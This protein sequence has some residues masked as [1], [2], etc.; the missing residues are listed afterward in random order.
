MKTFEISRTIDI[1]AIGF[2]LV[3]VGISVACKNEGGGPATPSGAVVAARRD[4]APPPALAPTATKWLSLSTLGLRIE[5]PGDAKAEDATGTS[6]NV[7]SDAQPSCFIML[8]KEDP[9]L[10]DK[11]EKVLENIKGGK[12]GHGPMKSMSKSEKRADGSWRIE[13]VEASDLDP[14]TELHG[15]DVRAVIGGALYGCSRKADSAAG[16]MCVAKACAS[17]KK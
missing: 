2:A 16:A 4:V 13:W 12:M 5:V 14:K 9:D 10:A 6:V 17:L 15:V 11:Y 7:T 3:A 8:S 1:R